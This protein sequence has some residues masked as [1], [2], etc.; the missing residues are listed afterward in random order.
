VEAR[1]I[2]VT[3]TWRQD[4][5]E[6][7]RRGPERRQHGGAVGQSGV[8]VEARRVGRVATQR[9]ASGRDLEVTSVWMPA[10]RLSVYLL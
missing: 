6:P 1:R 5:S 3:V 8:D 4:R 7:W 9:V 10:G 2:R